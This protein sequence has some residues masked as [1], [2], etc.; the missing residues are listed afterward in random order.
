MIF[1]LKY[2]NSNKTYPVPLQFHI[3][4]SSSFTANIKKIHRCKM[5]MLRFER[6]RLTTT[7]ISCVTY[8]SKW[9][10][11]ARPPLSHNVF[12]IHLGARA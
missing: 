12:I 9:W 10:L 4:S 11:V 5:Q 8:N 1:C 2:N 6:E 3:L 7:T